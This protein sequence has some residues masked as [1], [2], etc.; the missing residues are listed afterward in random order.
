MQQ[1]HLIFWAVRSLIKNWRLPQFST[2][3]ELE[4]WQKKQIEA[5]L[6][7]LAQR[8]AWVKEQLAQNSD[9]TQWP[10]MDKTQMLKHFN[11][12]NTANLDLEQVQKTAEEA[13]KIRHF[14]QTLRGYTVGL[15]SGTSGQR[16]V[17]VVSVRERAEWVAY[18]LRTL[19]PLKL[20]QQKVAFFLRANSN[21]Y[22]SV[23]SYFFNF[24][25]FDLKE[26]ISMLMQQL[27]SFRPDVLVAP[28]SVL[29]HIAQQQHKKP[30]L[31]PKRIISVAE[32]LEKQDETFIQ[33]TFG[34]IVHQAYQCTEGFLASTCSAGRLHFHE[35]IVQI[36]KQYLDETKTKYHPIIT[37]FRRSTQP[38]LR[39]VLNDIIHES[40]EKCPCGSVFEVI[41][42]IEG[43]SDDV[44]V[45]ANTQ[46]LFP[47][48]LRQFI[49]TLP[50]PP[51]D[52]RLLQVSPQ[53]IHAHLIFE[54]HKES[55]MMAFL[56]ALEATLKEKKINE[57]VIKTHDFLPPEAPEQKLRRIKRLF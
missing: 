48:T 5:H 19:L 11:R 6:K 47:D 41:S 54:E 40:T 21:L 29:L 46:K 23:K 12:L 15:S 30:F 42:Q 53:I 22:E 45:F 39:Y 13:E 24:C 10:S 38:I 17:F 43:R 1:I 55:G 18:V 20:K 2:R 9:W 3:K 25:F 4:A 28:S 34:Q 35:D 57:V 37:D 51:D 50:N 33:K 36:E 52:Y 16:G 49:Y 8:S 7:H 26:P 14:K 44:F 27:E 32:V 56:T 31:S